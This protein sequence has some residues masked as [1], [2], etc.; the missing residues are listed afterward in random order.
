MPVFEEKNG[1]YRFHCF[2]RGVTAVFSGRRYTLAAAADFLKAAGLSSRTLLLVRQIHS[3]DVCYV[4]SREKPSMETEADGLL[5]TEPPFAL[6]IKTA[7]CLP[8]FLEDPVHHAIG[9][10]HAGWRG[11]HAGIL[12]NALRR[13]QARF[14]TRPQDLTAAIGPAIRS[15]CYEVGPEFQGYF[16]EHFKPGKRSGEGPGGMLDLAG[17]AFAELQKAGISKEKSMD[18]GLCT[19]CHNGLFYSY[20]KE[21]TEERMLS[22]LAL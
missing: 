19:A 7:D 2:S 8:V 4:S 3:P 14:G 22:I 11:L 10:V 21:K 12:G 20:R 15:C 18:S 1:V 6:G 5:T 17:A 16:P 9:L 13:M